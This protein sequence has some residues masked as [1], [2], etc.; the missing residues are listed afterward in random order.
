VLNGIIP[1]YIVGGTSIATPLSAGMTTEQASPF[2]VGS[3]HSMGF[4]GDG[5]IKP[6]ASLNYSITPQ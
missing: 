2:R 6:P 5:F 3:S 4:H 1:P